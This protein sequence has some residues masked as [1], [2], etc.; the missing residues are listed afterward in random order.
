[1]GRKSA[2]NIIDA[3]VES[4]KASPTRLLFALGIRNV[5]IT[6]ARLLVE[7]YRSLEVISGMDEESLAK[8][9]TI[10]PKIADSIVKFFANQPQ[11]IDELKAIGFELKE[12]GV[13]QVKP[14]TGKSFLF[15]GELSSCTRNDAKDR[16]EA[17]GG[18]VK[19]SINKALDYVV[20]GEKPGSKLK[21]ATRPASA[22]NE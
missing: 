19:D 10:G 7:T 15:T 17:L 5:G 1:M 9:P 18:V 6:V 2:Q 13:T 11:L 3:V 22:Y 12:Q 4:R 16:V 20:V 8:T 14:F 21:K